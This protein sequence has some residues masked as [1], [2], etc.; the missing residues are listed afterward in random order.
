M[1]KYKP[2]GV[3]YVAGQKFHVEAPVVN[4]TEGPKW[5]ATAK[6]CLPTDNNG[7]RLCTS[8]EGFPSTVAY[9]QRYALRPALR[10]YGEHPPLDAVKAVIK[11]FVVHH[12]GCSSSDM[13]FDVL[14][15]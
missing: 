11:Q 15:N 8:P 4:F 1:G 7:M 3:I 5:D 13:C 12:D 9:N 14:Q 10:H 6:T 2:S